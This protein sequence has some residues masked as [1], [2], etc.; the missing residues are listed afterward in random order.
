VKKPYCLISDTHNHNWSAFSTMLPTGVNSR[1]QATLDEFERAAVELKSVGGHVTYHAGDL[2]HVR[3][4]VAPSVVNP[5]SDQLKR[6]LAKHGVGYTLDAGNH[7]LEGKHSTRLGNACEMIRDDKAVKVVSEPQFF[8]HHDGT[9]V[10]VVPWHERIADLKATIESEARR[11]ARQ[12]TD[13][14][15]HAPVDGVIPG[16][17]DH[18]LTPAYLASLG[19]K[20]VFAGHYH[21][22]KDFG[23]GVY[24]IGALTHLSWS[25]VGSKA[26]FL[27][28]Y[29]DKV[30]WRCTHAPQFVEVTDETD[31]T[32]IKL[33]ADGN[34][35]RI[36]VKSGTSS[37][38][39]NELREWLEKDCGAKGVRLDV[40]KAPTRVREGTGSIKAGSSVEASIA[41]FI[42]QKGFANVER[43]MA[44]ALKVLAEAA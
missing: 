16:L 8:E 43:V 23:N 33:L 12:Q 19:F 15:I 37:A 40:V 34:F 31:P 18:G 22:F 42:K 5:T 3:G 10:L 41:E 2:F 38:Q 11:T 26:G 36:K 25:D 9:C 24:S 13:L 4:S 7:D 6:A 35:V 32:E 14:I 44:D 1:L 27:I 28:V 17:P 30:D 39:I 21:N 29:D 20:R